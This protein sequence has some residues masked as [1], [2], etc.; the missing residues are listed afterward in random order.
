MMM[1]IMIPIMKLNRDVDKQTAGND[2][3]DNDD[4]HYGRDRLVA[5]WDSCSPVGFC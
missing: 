3:N 4:S 2:C 1:M 5:G